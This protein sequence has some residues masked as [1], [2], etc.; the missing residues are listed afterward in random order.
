MKGGGGGGEEERRGRRVIQSLSQTVV[1]AM[2]W[3]WENVRTHLSFSSNY[4][5]I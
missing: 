3:L 2:F 1:Y 4:Q 5:V